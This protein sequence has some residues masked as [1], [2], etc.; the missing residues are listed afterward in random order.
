[1][2]FKQ[3]DSF[4]VANS[5]SQKYEQISFTVIPTSASVSA[6]FI[7]EHGN[8]N[9]RPLSLLL[10]NN[11]IVKSKGHVERGADLLLLFVRQ[12]KESHDANQ[13]VLQYWVIIQYY[14]DH[15]QVAQRSPRPAKNIL[16]S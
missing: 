7:I 10:F 1:M 16:P 15:A 3:V 5:V 11:E 13:N 2:S 8:S 9:R 4:S 12:H 14:R 6:R